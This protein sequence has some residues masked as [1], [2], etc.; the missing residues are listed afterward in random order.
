MQLKTD[1]SRMPKAHFQC[2]KSLGCFPIVGLLL[3]TIIVTVG[4]TVWVI[5][6]QLF[7]KDFKPVELSQSEQLTLE[8]KLDAL[9]N[10]EEGNFEETS[11]EETPSS[12]FNDNN[13]TAEQIADSIGSSDTN[14]SDEGLSLI[15]I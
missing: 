12:E 9:A 5:Q 11:L 10:F 13:S 15:H 8:Q 6:S 1:L 3:L 2:G 14:L 4:A 7:A